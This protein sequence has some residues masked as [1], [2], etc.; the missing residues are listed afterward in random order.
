MFRDKTQAEE[1]TGLARPSLQTK[2]QFVLQTKSKQKSV[3]REYAEALIVALLLALFIR[4][5]IVQAFKIPSGSMLPTLQI[6]DHILVN[7]FLYGLRLP[8]PFEKVIMQ[9]GQ[10]HEGDVIV[11]IYPRDRTKDFIKRVI[12]VEGDTIEIRHKQVYVNNEKLVVPQATFADNNAEIPGLRD[13]FGPVTVPPHKLFVMGDNRD[14]SH[15]SRFW[16]FVDLNDVKGKAFL[17]YWSW[18][19]EDRWVRWERIGAL[20]R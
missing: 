1:A 14:R 4:S 16:G 13:N 15:D 10:P 6:G 12:A 11:F 5:F 3:A 8:Y 2:D 19:G 9:W 20:I 18:D 7:K 17:V